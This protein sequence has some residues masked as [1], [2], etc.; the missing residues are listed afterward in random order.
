MARKKTTSP[1]PAANPHRDRWLD[2][3]TGLLLREG[4]TGF[5][6]NALARE[7]GADK[8]LLY[9]HFGSTD[10]LL[11]SY[12]MERSIWPAIEDFCGPDAA[13]SRLQLRELRPMWR[14]FAILS[15]NGVRALRAHPVALEIFA[16][17]LG[18]EGNQLTCAQEILRTRMLRE[19]VQE[20]SAG[21][22]ADVA[23]LHTLLWNGLCMIAV[24]ER[25]RDQLRPK[26]WRR[27][28]EAAGIA[29]RRVLKKG[30]K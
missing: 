20:F 11:R 22:K 12:A 15:E 5:G 10:E 23:A 16:W 17:S 9:R 27:L 24:Q 2:A 19:L 7:A 26:D 1:E 14:R 6:I 29:Y 13:D 21:E 3:L 18:P 4:Y 30:K 25:R 28:E 8:A